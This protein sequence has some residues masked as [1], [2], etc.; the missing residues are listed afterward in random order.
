MRQAGKGTR[1][2][3]IFIVVLAFGVLDH[4]WWTGL[5]AALYR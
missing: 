2:V 5:P 3:L 1:T 4:L